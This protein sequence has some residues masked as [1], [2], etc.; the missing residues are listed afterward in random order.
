MD[1]LY[2]KIIK[3]KP[4]RKS[5]TVIYEKTVAIVNSDLQYQLSIANKFKNEYRQNKSIIM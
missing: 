1:E 5:K 4:K 2:S 3:F